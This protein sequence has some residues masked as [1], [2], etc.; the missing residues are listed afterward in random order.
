MSILSDAP[1]KLV[2][3]MV[4]AFLPNEYVLKTTLSNGAIL[5]LPMAKARGF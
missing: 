4:V 5:N 1:D 3:K 2:R